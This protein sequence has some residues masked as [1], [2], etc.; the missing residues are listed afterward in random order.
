[1]RYSSKD[2]CGSPGLLRNGLLLGKWFLEWSLSN[3]WLLCSTEPNLTPIDLGT[4]HD[5]FVGPFFRNPCH[6]LKL[7][8][9][10]S[11]ELS[12]LLRQLRLQAPWKS[13][14]E[15][16]PWFL[17]L[18]ELSELVR[19]SASYIRLASAVIAVCLMARFDMD[20]ILGISTFHWS[21]IGSIVLV[22]TN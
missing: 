16:P 8:S 4:L 3:G 18:I 19:T 5:G 14:H 6:S 7:S 9:P 22:W 15:F 20:V 1:M 11:L 12:L 2:I 17:S 10:K 13:R 21:S